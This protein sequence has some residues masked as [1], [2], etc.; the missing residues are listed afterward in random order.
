[1]KRIP[2]LTWQ[3]ND[4]QYSVRVTK[5]AFH[6]MLQLAAQ[7]APNEVG[8]SL[9]GSYSDDGSLAVVHRIAPL[10][11]DSRG[12]RN[13]FLRGILG[14]R[15][16]FGKVIARFRGRRHYVGEWHSHPGGIPVPSSTDDYNQT[17]IATDKVAHCPECILVILGGDFSD[18]PVL[19]LY[20]YSRS[21]GKIVL[22]PR[23]AH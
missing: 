3:S 22:R 23:D 19:G 10:S 12:S 7:H 16:F 18:D 2:P 13:A 4:R 11:A 15:T 9:V 1:M 20:V 21:R 6:S 5:P 17:A 14:L 8:T